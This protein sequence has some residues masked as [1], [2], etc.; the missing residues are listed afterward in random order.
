MDENVGGGTNIFIDD[1]SGNLTIRVWDSME[2]DSVSL[3][4][5][6]LLLGEL[7]GKR[8]SISGPSSTFNGDFQMLAGYAEDFTDPNPAGAPSGKLILDVPNRP[9]APDIGQTLPI[10][11]DSP[12]TAAVRLRLF[13]LRGQLVHTFV[14]KRAG[15]PKFLDWDGRNDLNELLPLGTYI[16]HLESIKDGETDSVTKPIVVGTRL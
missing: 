1:G 4:G 13:N 2:L 9:F 3:N 8:I 10:H 6:W 7:V 12:P 11:Y 16:L 14:D 15:G 5:E